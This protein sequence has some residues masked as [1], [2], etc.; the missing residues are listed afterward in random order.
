MQQPFSLPSFYC[1][2]F[3]R[4]L[5]LADLYRRTN[6]LSQLPPL[7][8]APGSAALTYFQKR[9]KENVMEVPTLILLSIESSELWAASIR[10]VI[11][12]PNPVPPVRLERSLLTL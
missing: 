1:L 7:K 11:E 6:R 8:S 12:S 5:S 10:F 2:A 3:I 4:Q 9:G